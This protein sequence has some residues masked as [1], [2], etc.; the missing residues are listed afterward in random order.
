ME[1]ETALTDAELVIATNGRITEAGKDF[2]LNEIRKGVSINKI[3]ANIGLGRTRLAGELSKNFG[4]TL[5]EATIVFDHAGQT[6]AATDYAP[7]QRMMNSELVKKDNE[8][9]K[10]D[11]AA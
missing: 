7:L 11:T 6:V 3:C 2:I 5:I 8:P 4:L 10:K 9:A 1:T